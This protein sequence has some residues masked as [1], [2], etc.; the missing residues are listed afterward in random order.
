ML[1]AFRHWVRR[2]LSWWSAWDVPGIGS[3][4]HHD[5]QGWGCGDKGWRAAG[6]V[7]AHTR[8]GKQGCCSRRQPAEGCERS[9]LHQVRCCWCEMGYLMRI[10]F[11]HCVLQWGTGLLRFLF[12]FNFY[13]SWLPRTEPLLGR[14][15]SLTWMLLVWSVLNVEWVCMCAHMGLCVCAV[16]VWACV[17]MCVCV[18]VCP[19][20][21]VCV[22]CVSGYTMCVC[23]CGFVCDF[24]TNSLHS[25]TG[26]NIWCS[27]SVSIF[28]WCACHIN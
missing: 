23:L 15:S 7:T 28:T 17:C 12:Y 13:Y 2:L 8:G 11:C 3:G 27:F 10:C 4:S 26:R 6:L 21:C 25:I 22:P 20:M 9:E 19:C 24:V 1:T 14:E 5:G 16:C 18:C